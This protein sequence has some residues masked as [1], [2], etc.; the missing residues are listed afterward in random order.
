MSSQTNVVEPDAIIRGSTRH[1][2]FTLVEL[3]IALILVAIIGVLVIGVLRISTQTWSRVS[4]QRDQSEQHF[5]VIQ[6][7]RRHLSDMR[8]PLVHT[9]KGQLIGAFGGGGE[10]IRFVA[11]FP[12]YERSG[13]LY[14]W[15]L[16][17]TVDD[18]MVADSEDSAGL[19][20]HYQPFDRDI[21]YPLSPSGELELPEEDRK[22]LALA[23]DIS[24][25][26]VRFFAA[27]KRAGSWREDWRERDDA[28]LA[29]GLALEV[30]DAEGNGQPLPE[31]ILS[32]RFSGLD[33]QKP[34]PTDSSESRGAN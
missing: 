20:L 18:G 12:T 14:W 21:A 8:F 29:I 33:D 6:A 7:L 25:V 16:S 11:P 23:D 34:Q 26:G 13:E 2:G 19:Q 24:L 5:L 10:S 17:S 15:T 22:L 9:D 31:I 3:Q 32:T 30:R 28:P 4:E 27:G 1:Q